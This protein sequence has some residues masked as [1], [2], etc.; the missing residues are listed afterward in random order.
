MSYQNVRFRRAF[1]IGSVDRFI[2]D[3]V[4]PDTLFLMVLCRFQQKRLKIYI[5]DIVK[6]DKNISYLCENQTLLH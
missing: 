5:I 1:F 6:M 3:F 4:F 2:G